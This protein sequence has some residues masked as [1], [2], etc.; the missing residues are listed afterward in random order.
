MGCFS[1]SFGSCTCVEAVSEIN[2]GLYIMIIIQFRILTWKNIVCYSRDPILLPCLCPAP[3]QWSCS[4]RTCFFIMSR[5]ETLVRPEVRFSC[6]IC[7]M[8]SSVAVKHESPL[9]CA[10]V[11]NQCEKETCTPRSS[12]SHAAIKAGQI[13]PA[14]PCT[15]PGSAYS[16]RSRQSRAPITFCCNKDA[17]TS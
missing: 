7:S 10:Y 5:H 12:A 2:I 6:Q 4:I 3:C 9:R 16:H 8:I 11:L 1:I 15:T 17:S 14:E 13:N